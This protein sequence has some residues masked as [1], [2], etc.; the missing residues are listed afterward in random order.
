MIK[1]SVPKCQRD[2]PNVP[3]HLGDKATWRCRPCCGVVTLPDKGKT[4]AETAQ[5]MLERLASEAG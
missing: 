1:C 3:E 4:L 2:L 5:A